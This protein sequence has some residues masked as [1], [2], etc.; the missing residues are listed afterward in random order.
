MTV[1]THGY[2]LNASRWS[3]HAKKGNVLAD[4]TSSLIHKITIKNNCFVN[5]INITY[6]TEYS[7]NVYSNGNV[8]YES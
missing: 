1:F 4:N 8:G 5:S 6:I 7:D 3:N 2:D